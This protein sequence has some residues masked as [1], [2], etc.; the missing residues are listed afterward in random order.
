[1]L[2]C[3]NPKCENKF[4]AKTVT[5]K[6]CTAECRKQTTNENNNRKYHEDKARRAGKLERVCNICQKTKLN[7]YNASSVCGGCEAQVAVDARKK[8]LKELGY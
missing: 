7:R 3:A 4:S 6:F 2:T 5:Q 8:L 1:M